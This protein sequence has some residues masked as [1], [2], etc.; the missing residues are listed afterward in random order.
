MKRQ[1]LISTAVLGV[2][3]IALSSNKA[4][5]ASSG[6]GIRNGGPGTNGTCTACHGGGQGTTTVSISLKEKANGNA[7][8]GKYKPGTVY[9][10]T[11][12]G[13]NPNLALWGFQVTAVTANHTQAGNFSNA[14]TGKHVIP[15]SGLQVVEHTTT[16]SKTNNM[17]ETEFD[18]TAP[19]TGTGS[20][21]FHGIINAVNDDNSTTGDRVSAPATLTL[22]EDGP[23][24]IAE[25][26]SWKD[27]KLYPNPATDELHISSNQVESGLYELSVYDLSGKQVWHSTK[28][29]TT[30]TLDLVIPIRPLEAGVYS[31]SIKGKQ[32]AVLMFVKK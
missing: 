32:Q 26:L 31:L 29:I 27:L 21:M 25:T 24:S 3:Y 9:T 11:I 12:S 28:N 23:T 13:N 2:L 17:Y 30:N 18:W 6:N 7:A 4:G 10:V 19:A 16:L 14:G 20:I 15:I 8:N 22:T 5:P 1:L